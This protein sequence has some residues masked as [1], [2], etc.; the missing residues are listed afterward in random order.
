MLIVTN[1]TSAIGAIRSAGIEAEFLAWDDVLHDGPVRPAESLEDCSRKRATYLASLGWGTVTEIHR[2]FQL[3]DMVFLNAVQVEGRLGNEIVLWFEHDLYDQLQILQILYEV[4]RRAGAAARLSMICHDHYVAMSDPDTLREDL[5]A[6]APITSAQVLLAS[7][8]WE[9]F[10]TGNR[11]A[12]EALVSDEKTRLLPFLSR[13]LARLLEEYP[14]DR[15]GLGRTERSILGLLAGAGDEGLTGG[16]LFRQQQ[17]TEDAVFMGD[18]SFLQRITGLADPG[19]GLVE[20]HRVNDN[21][22]DLR[23]ITVSLTPK[24][25][26]VQNGTE[27]A[28]ESVPDHW[29]GG[30]H[31]GAG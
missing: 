11:A 31:F 5:Q 29:I 23:H 19:R 18:A 21:D 30:A 10:T 6:R 22:P 13:A 25:L 1:G 9:A 12:L 26:R 27:S 14:S 3:R 2:R 4:G 16:M 8:A 24:G 15:D 17:E 20:L 7:G 28:A